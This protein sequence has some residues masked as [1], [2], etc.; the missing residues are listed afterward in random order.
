[1]VDS[2]IAFTDKNNIVT[3]EQDVV[4]VKNDVGEFKIFEC[5]ELGYRMLQ[6]RRFTKMQN[7]C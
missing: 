5:D 3:K 7:R 2:H 1:M 4:H 6:D